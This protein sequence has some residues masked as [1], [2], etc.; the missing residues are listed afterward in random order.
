MKRKTV[1]DA[2]VEV[3]HQEQ[4]LLELLLLL[5]MIAV[6]HVEAQ[7]KSKNKQGGMNLKKIFISILVSSLLLVGC[8]DSSYS[9]VDVINEESISNYTTLIDGKM[10]YIERGKDDMNFP[11]KYSSFLKDNP[12]LEVI[13][14]ES[15]P[16]T[17][18]YNTTKGYF[19]F[20]KA[21]D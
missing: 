6:I 11:I 9:N 19:I 16:K 15:D 17:G 14:V 7:A 8:Q 3:I 5:L 1:T 10:Y 21:L 20:T 12:N 2:L 13:D 4:S 18:N